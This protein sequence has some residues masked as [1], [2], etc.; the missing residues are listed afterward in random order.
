MNSWSLA[1]EYLALILLAII[2]LFFYD[3]NPLRSS[4]NRRRLYWCG[5]FLSAMST[6]L[7]I[8]CVNFLESEKAYPGKLLLVLN[9]AYFFV[10][11]IMTLVIG[12]YI[13]TR[14]LEFVYNS[15]CLRNGRIF[16]VSMAIGYSLLLLLNM[17]G[18]FI[19]YF[20]AAGEYC[21]GALHILSYIPPV[22][23]VCIVLL[24]YIRNRKSVSEVTQKLF[25]ATATVAVFLMLFQF[26]YPNEQL[27]GMI[28]ATVN[29]IVFMSYNGGRVDR[30]NLTGLENRRY[31]M[32]ELRYRTKARQNYQLI[33]VKLTTLSRI[34]K[35]YGENGGN[36]LLF[37]VSSS[38][39]KL[40]AEGSKGGQDEGRIFRYGGATF[41]ILFQDT[42][43]LLCTTRLMSIAK[44][45]RGR[46]ILGDSEITLPFSEVELRYSGQNWSLEEVRGYLND[47]MVLSEKEGTDLIPFD[48]SLLA[49]RLRR[50]AVLDSLRSAIAENRLEVWYQPIYYRESGKFESAEALIRMF[51]ERGNSIPPSEFIPVAEDSG[52]IDDVTTF[53][54][55]N[56]CRLIKSETVPELRAI[57]VNVPIQQVEDLEFRESLCRIIKRY[58]VSPE[59]IRIEITERDVEKNG[60]AA[61]ETMQELKKAGYRLLLDD[62]GIG[63]SNLARVMSM[64]LDIIKIDRSLVLFEENESSAELISK[65]FVPLFHSM[66]R[67]V[68]AEGI[69]T[70]ETAERLLACGVDSIQGYYYARPMSEERLIKWYQNSRL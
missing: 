22:C 56:V 66:G 28:C 19:F 59:R 53:V 64:P 41:A 69:E 68:V 26:F 34:N 40:M 2:A 29:L 27:N 33:L 39:R 1:G 4:A 25:F 61:L 47:A 46:F 31:L 50:H 36:A 10:V 5:L 42:D 37:Q 6:I 17:H 38:L 16:H 57:S 67:S 30:D 32:T 48:K 54:L 7:N 63:Y 21:R 58:D 60:H 51:D 8:V 45:M 70:A 18:G 35:S 13:F 15:H 55:E 62:F 11:C 24:C 20:N 44:L 3:A 49:Q 52:L 23:E 12:Y 43:P 9:T 65:Y 14:V